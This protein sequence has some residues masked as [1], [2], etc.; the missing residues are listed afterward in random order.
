MEGRKLYRSDKGSM[1]GERL[2]TSWVKESKPE[3]SGLKIW[4]NPKGSCEEQR[5]LVYSGGVFLLQY[6]N[7]RSAPLR[8]CHRI[9]RVQRSI[10]SEK[11]PWMERRSRST[12]WD[13]NEPASCSLHCFLEGLQI[14]VYLFHAHNIVVWRLCW[15]NPRGD[16]RLISP[17]TIR[18]NGA[19]P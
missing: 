3:R 12:I 14:Q 16:R 9:L 1:G 7:W 5:E 13:S 17:N 10:L 8:G 4:K 11:G 18:S 15:P 6:Y 19:P 2:G